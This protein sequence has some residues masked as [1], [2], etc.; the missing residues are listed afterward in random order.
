[1]KL[2][3]SH[4]GD[5]EKTHQRFL[6]DTASC[7][8]SVEVVGCT[9]TLPGCGKMVDCGQL[10]QDVCGD[11]KIQYLYDVTNDAEESYKYYLLKNRKKKPD[12]QSIA[13]IQSVS[14]A[15]N[16]N[17]RNEPVPT[18]KELKSAPSCPT[19]SVF[20]PLDDLSLAPGQS[21][22]LK[23]Q[24]YSI[25][26]CECP[27]FVFGG[28]AFGTEGTSSKSSKKKKKNSV[29]VECVA[30]DVVKNLAQPCETYP[31][32]GRVVAAK[33][34]NKRKSGNGINTAGSVFQAAGLPPLRGEFY[35][36]TTTVEGKYIVSTCRS[37][38]SVDF[39]PLIFKNTGLM[40][41]N[42]QTL[43]AENQIT[44]MSL[45]CRE[46]GRRELSTQPMLERIVVDLQASTDY[47]VTAGSDPNAM[48]NGKYTLDVRQND[49][50]NMPQQ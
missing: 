13:V 43:T 3:F 14:E 41:P 26:L 11:V 32:K 42:C 23:S 49:T 17:A 47:F 29:D 12:D 20:I 27:E 33:K 25:N 2:L 40:E 34:K 45:P 1:M 16:R 10:K 30:A 37:S 4:E 31:V 39:K 22:T 19:D 8:I 24:E 46:A 48:G 5:H 36:F 21:K 38:G 9:A 18:P 6:E 35:N 28:A 44:G 15:F 50:P 7:D